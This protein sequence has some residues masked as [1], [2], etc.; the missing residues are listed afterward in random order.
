MFVLF[1]NVILLLVDWQWRPLPEAVWHVENIG[2]RSVLH[3]VAAVG[4]GLVLYGTLLINHLDLFGMRP[5]WLYFKGKQYTPVRFKERV[6]YRWVRHP[7]MLGVL[8]AFWATPDMTQGHLLF[9]VVTTVY[10]IIAIRIEERTLVA[11]HGE[12]YQRYQKRVSM[13]IP[14]PPRS[15][16]WPEGT[17]MQK[18][19]VRMNSP[20]SVCPWSVAAAALFAA[21]AAAGGARA[22]QWSGDRQA[23]V[24]AAAIET[25]Y[26]LGFTFQ[27]GHSFNH[28][29]GQE[30]LRVFNPGRRPISVRFAVFLSPD[31]VLTAATY[32]GYAIGG[33]IAPGESRI[34][35]CEGVNGPVEAVSLATGYQP[36]ERMS[37]Y[38]SPVFVVRDT[39]QAD[40][41][42]E[43]QR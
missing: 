8:V 11:L 29:M 20:S 34:L 18:A 32:D 2:G 42:D 15:G 16:A 30:Q 41:S 19:S 6:L 17:V 37:L 36:D 27:G 22:D 13:I 38:V 33:N 21:V 23:P 1:T 28:L 14:L 3:V 31:K 4:W 7:L 39:S 35:F 26:V 9:A 5:V 10:I 43:D 25:P 24:E 40:A 12:D